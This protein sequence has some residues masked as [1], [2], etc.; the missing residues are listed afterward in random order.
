MKRFSIS[1]VTKELKIKT[2]LW[3]YCILIKMT[4]IQNTQKQCFL[5]TLARMWNHRCVLT[6]CWGEYK[7]VQL[8]RK[9]KPNMFFTIQ[10]N[11]HTPYYLYK[12]IENLCSHE[13]LHMDV[14]V[15]LFIITKTWKQ[16]RCPLVDGWVSELWY[17]QTINS[18]QC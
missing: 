14:Y 3:L 4:K 16:P 7:A 10:S 13:N 5:Q 9:T 12:R 8:L 1:Y 17:I 11:N 2:I 18:I 15:A 6:P